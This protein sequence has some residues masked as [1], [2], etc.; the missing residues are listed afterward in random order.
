MLLVRWML[1]SAVVGVSLITSS[2]T[3]GS[4]MIDGVSEGVPTDGRCDGVVTD[5]PV[6]S[7]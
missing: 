7:G 5:L 2:G 4:S 1:I 6:A 3:I